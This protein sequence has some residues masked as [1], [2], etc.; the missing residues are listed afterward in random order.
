MRGR[1]LRDYL[2]KG[3]LMKK[4][5]ILNAGTRKKEARFWEMM[6]AAGRGLSCRK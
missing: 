1:I 6:L 2:N 4:K 5:K 3:G